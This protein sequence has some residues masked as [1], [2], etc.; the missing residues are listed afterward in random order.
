MGA[1]L[2][3][4]LRSLNYCCDNLINKL[5]RWCYA[6]MGKSLV[7]YAVLQNLLH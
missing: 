7:N 3:V 1:Q 6:Y 2:H 5:E 4:G